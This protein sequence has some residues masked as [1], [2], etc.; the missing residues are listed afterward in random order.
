MINKN[1]YLLVVTLFLVLN[2]VQAYFVTVDAHSEECF[3]DKAEAGTKMGE[4]CNLLTKITYQYIIFQY[5]ANVR[6]GRRRLLRYRC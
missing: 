4:Y 3:F 5:R 2:N 1:Y 6:N